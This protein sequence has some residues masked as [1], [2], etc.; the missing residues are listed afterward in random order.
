MNEIKLIIWDLD[1]TLWKGTLA[2]QE[3]V[4]LNQTLVD[5][6]RFLLD[7][8]IV[9]SICSKNDA[10][11]A[12]KVLK[13]FGIYDLFIFPKI[14]FADKGLQ[15]K[16]IINEAQLREQNVLFVDDNEFVLR[17]AQYHNP[18]MMV[19]LVGDFLEQDITAWGK[20]DPQRERLAQ[21]KILEKKERRKRSFLKKSQDEQAFLNECQINVQ[22]IP[23]TLNDKD[24]E[25]VIDLVNRA[26]QLNFTQSRIKYEY[27]FTLFEL[28]NGLNFK[29]HVKDKYGDYGIVGYVCIMK[30]SLVHF[31]FSCRTLGMRVE[32]RTLQWIKT[33]YPSVTLPFLPSKIKDAQTNLDFI[34]IAVR[35]ETAQAKSLC[36][37]QKLLVRG[38]CLSNAISFLLGEHYQVDEEIFSFFEY[39]NL[40]FL[41]KHLKDRQDRRFDKSIKA[42]EQN[43]YPLII[44][45]LESD[46]Y[47][48]LYRLG[49][50]LIPVSSYYVFWKGLSSIR[51]DNQALAQHI[52]A[53]M[54]NGMQDVKKFN[55]G[56]QFSPWPTLEKIANLTLGWFGESW[57]K[58][59]HKLFFLSVYKKY[60][61]YVTPEEFTDN[62][63]WY[64]DL[65][66]TSTKLLFINPPE[67][68]N[69]P[70]LNGDQN[71]KIAARTKELNAIMRNIA[72][73][74]PNVLLLEMNEIL[75]Q[76]DIIDSF[77]HLKR[78][79]YIKLSQSLLTIVK[80][81][82]GGKK[83]AKNAKAV[84]GLCGQEV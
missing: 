59:M 23:L 24:I 32:A 13:D 66:P 50:E 77:S 35:Q 52:D 72:K 46:Y 64:I 21:Y 7:R 30:N 51:E 37:Q 44:N 16:Q 18:T 31:V 43:E 4:V 38:P 70:Y 76:E 14:A 29:V 33:H 67:S 71:Q 48:G 2:E 10:R 5:R 41:R 49:K 61:G 62:L 11:K 1:D 8:G 45:F 57:M 25:R 82:L 69:L 55:L 79:G 84:P 9:H 80:A 40:H 22:L 68:I 47:S 42:M 36:Q 17:E 65:F 3:Q 6:I 53:M 19:Q 63:L 60:S 73:Y 56:N 20:P 83:K 74:K 12:K 81:S 75:E 54:L 26:N 78:Q 28:K 39:A 34:T 58:L 15:I 27:L